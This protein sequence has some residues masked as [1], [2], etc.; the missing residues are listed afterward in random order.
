MYKKRKKVIKEA[1]NQRLEDICI[2]LLKLNQDAFFMTSKRF[3]EKP[4]KTLGSEIKNTP[5]IISSKPLEELSIP[6]C[7]SLKKDNTLTTWCDTDPLIKMMYSKI[8][9]HDGNINGKNIKNLY[10]DIENQDEYNKL[11]F[12]SFKN[13]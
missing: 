6:S 7:Y 11:V 13:Y 4:D 10:M 8:T 12:K 3:V 9:F 1:I 2:D 5:V